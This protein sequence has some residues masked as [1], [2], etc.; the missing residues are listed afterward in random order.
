MRN[1]LA[2][3]LLKAWVL[4]VDDKYLPLAA[5]DLTIL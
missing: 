4:L 1:K 2:L 5:N 3:A